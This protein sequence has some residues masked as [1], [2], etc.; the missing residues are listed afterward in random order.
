MGFNSG[1]KG[2]KDCVIYQFNNNLKFLFGNFFVMSLF[3]SLECVTRSMPEKM[4]TGDN[5]SA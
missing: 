4:V 2:L 5:R 3:G 1:F